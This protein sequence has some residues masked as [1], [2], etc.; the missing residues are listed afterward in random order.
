MYK[1]SSVCIFTRG[2]FQPS[3]IVIACICLCVRLSVFASVYHPIVWPCENSSTVQDGT[4]KFKQIIQNTFVKVPIDFEADWLWSLRSNVTLNSYITSFWACSH[5]NSPGIRG[6]P[7]LDQKCIVALSGSLLILGFIDLDLEFDFLFQ[8]PFSSKLSFLAPLIFKELVHH[9]IIKFCTV[10][11]WGL[12]IETRHRLG[13]NLPWFQYTSA[14]YKKSAKPP[15]GNSWKLISKIICYHQYHHL[16]FWK[17]LEMCPLGENELNY[18]P[19]SHDSAFS[20]DTSFI[21]LKL[22]PVAKPF[23]GIFVPLSVIPLGVCVW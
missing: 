17:C 10:C 9:R 23:H 8:N 11:Q 18:L 14:W 15:H 13:W 7:N 2:Q 20:C 19:E 5:Y 3:G 12:F 1:S 21:I 16:F 6:Y 4:T 22:D